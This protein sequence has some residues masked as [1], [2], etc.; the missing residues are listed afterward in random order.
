MY[1]QTAKAIISAKVSLRGQA[2]THRG[3]RTKQTRSYLPIVHCFQ[4]IF[5]HPC[6]AYP[7]LEFLCL[8]ICMCTIPTA[9]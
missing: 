6:T 3:K 1:T 5:I 8:F 9:M 4:S 7:P 2:T